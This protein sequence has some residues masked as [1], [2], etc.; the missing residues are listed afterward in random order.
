MHG[1]NLSQRNFGKSREMDR[2]L[3]AER[4]F[5]ESR[6]VRRMYG[7]TLFRDPYLNG[8]IDGILWIAAKGWK[9]ILRRFTS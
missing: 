5:V 7:V 9:V 2:I 3:S 1:G 8:L 6:A 4:Q